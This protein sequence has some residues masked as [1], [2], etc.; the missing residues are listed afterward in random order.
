MY[1]T[2]RGT[3]LRRRLRAFFL[4]A[5]VSDAALLA[6]LRHEQIL[7]V[8]RNVTAL[9]FSRLG[10]A[11]VSVLLLAGQVPDLAL[12][13]WVFVFLVKSAVDER[14][15][16]RYRRAA[17]AGRSTPGQLRAVVMDAV[18]FA[19]IW[20]LLALFLLF[21]MPLIDMALL[22]LLV[23][24]V[25]IFSVMTLHP[26]LGA[27]Y[28][29]IV[30]ISAILL[31]LIPL[32]HQP[33]IG[34]QLAL[35][36]ML[37]VMGALVAR[38]SHL[39]FVEGALIK[40]QNRRLF[41]SAESASRAK[42]EFIANMSHELRTPLNAIIGFAEVMRAQ[43]Y[44]ALEA[45]YSEYVQDIESSGRH[46]LA[47]INDILDLSK[48]EAGRMELREEAVDLAELAAGCIGLLR[49]RAEQAGLDLVSLLRADLPE[50]WLDPLK[51]RQVLLNLL[52]NA[53]KFTPAG[54][55]IAVDAA[56]DA[57]G[58]WVLTVADTG[59]GMSADQIAV[60]MQPFGQID[61]R[62]SRAHTGTGLG[63]PL[64]RRLVEL[65]GGAL[66]LHSAPGQ[67]TQVSIRLP[68]SRLLHQAMARAYDI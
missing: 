34:V 64:A 31:L 11:A 28:A 21:D 18:L 23:G 55:R 50:F 5:P 54:G 47:L 45:H 6:D 24:A 35:L 25:M 65:H 4:P 27:A 22:V 49:A 63:L 56:M 3:G 38:S 7:A 33:H 2:E 68:A 46:L 14:Q 48:I 66:D 39:T 43:P 26:V 37:M 44:G 1:E 61:N 9:N 15:W 58:D 12:A 19:V 53:L 41:E 67:G 40:L 17:Q 62:L 59:I 13:L 42:S 16:R 52:S 30:P 60:A 51:I 10:L 29:Y 20:A 8:T 36:V 32:L 57:A